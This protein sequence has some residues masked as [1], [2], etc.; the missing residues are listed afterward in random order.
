[1][2]ATPAA[3]ETGKVCAV[4]RSV[5]APSP[6]TWLGRRLSSRNRGRIWIAASGLVDSADADDGEVRGLAEVLN[7]DVVVPV[8]SVSVLPRGMFIEGETPTPR[9]YLLDGQSPPQQLGRRF[10]VP[11]WEPELLDRL[12]AVR[13]AAARVDLTVT[14]SQA[15]SCCAPRR[16]LSAAGARTSPWVC[17][18]L[19]PS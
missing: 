17:R 7:R 13:K 15:V 16:R 10:P 3:V 11:T 19:Y 12:D 4:L 6:R 9:W 8:G 18:C 5:L 2:I 14:E 1:M